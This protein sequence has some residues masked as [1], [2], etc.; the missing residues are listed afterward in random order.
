MMKVSITLFIILCTFTAFPQGYSGL[1]ARWSFNGN[2]NDVSGNGL[3]G[4]VYGP[5]LTTGYSGLPNTAYL[6]NGT[7]D[8]ISVPYNSLMNAKIHSICVLIKPISFY[9]GICQGN[10]ILCRGQENQPDFYGFEY[11]DNPY[12]NDCTIYSPANDVFTGSTGSPITSAPGSAWYMPPAIIANTWNCVVF[13]YD[14]TDARIYINGVLRTTFPFT[15]NYV[16]STDSLIIGKS[17]FGPVYPYFTNAII[18]EI[19]LYNR[20]LSPAEAMAFCDTAEAPAP[21]HSCNSIVLPDSIHICIDS[22]IMLPASIAGADSI[23]SISWSPSIGLSNPAVLTPTLTA[24]A[25]SLWYHLTVRSLDPANLVVNGDFS[26]GNTGFTSSY[27]Y[28]SP[29][30][31][32]LWLAGVYTVDTDPANDHPSAYSFHDHTTGSGNMMMMNGASTP[33]GVWCETIPVTPNT[34]YNFSAW[35]SNWSSDTTGNLPLIQFQVNGALLGSGTFSFVPTPG[36]WTQFASTWNS[37]TATS[38]NICIYDLQTAAVGN[39]FAIDDILFQ[40][41]CTAVDSVYI[42]VSI[43]GFNHHRYD[44]S[45][46]AGLGSASLNA[47]AGYSSYSWNTG[48]S[49]S[50]IPVSTAGLYWVTAASSCGGLQDTFKVTL[51][52]PDT[53]HVRKDT[54]VCASVG[55]IVIS[56][57]SG[58][59]SW[60]W[61]TGSTSFSIT[62]SSTGTYWVRAVNNNTCNILIDTFHTTFKP[63]PVVF[64]GKDT[65]ICQ[66]DNITLRSPQPG[67]AT[68]QWNTGSTDSSIIASPGKTYSLTVTQNGCSGSASINIATLYQPT[69]NL[70]PD[71][72]LCSGELLNLPIAAGNGNLIWSDGSMGPSF[73]AS[74]TGTYWATLTN[75]CGSVSDTVHLVYDFCDLWFPSAFTPNGDGINDIIRVVGSLREYKDFS[76]GIFNRWG[77]RVFYTQDIY[78]GWDGKFNGVRQEI[79]TYF[80]QIFYSLH[81]KKGMMKGDFEL[82]K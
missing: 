7:S 18:D 76:L 68:Y 44:T 24:P 69:L 81:G 51:I 17:D 19:R 21:S 42:D 12:D 37:G 75:P 55:S 10:Y 27:S 65:S 77:Q 79:G 58:Y 82:I 62:A 47:P 6:F 3:N 61:N 67:T 32:A 78:Q 33:V 70:G 39:D 34:D 45:L 30:P 48:A 20:V 59:T 73:T 16:N 22:T 74:V 29:A 53:L 66:G 46:C 52:A 50:S 40:Q 80:Y 14:G 63:M 38:A 31:S 36:R 72:T 41:I 5:T 57:P 9:S 64:L 35:F 2:A 25:T 56:T 13:T 49:S 23:L 54:S 43:S 71:T 4:S 1:V 60:L 15:C 26:A 11:H 8:F 28:V